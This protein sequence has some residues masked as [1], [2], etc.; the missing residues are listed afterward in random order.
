VARA[1]S[2]SVRMSRMV[3]GVVVAAAGEGG[4][5]EDRGGTHG[6]LLARLSPLAV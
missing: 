4:N 3:P 2:N 1:N 5:L 6:T